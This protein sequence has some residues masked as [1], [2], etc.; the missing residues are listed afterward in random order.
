[1][2]SVVLLFRLLLA[3]TKTDGQNVLSTVRTGYQRGASGNDGEL[4]CMRRVFFTW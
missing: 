2:H 3:V 1:M 4:T